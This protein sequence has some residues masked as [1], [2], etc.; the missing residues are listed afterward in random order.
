M[1]LNYSFGALV[2]S[3]PGLFFGGSK[4][5]CLA[6]NDDLKALKYSMLNLIITL[7]LIGSITYLI[8]FKVFTKSS[9]KLPHIWLE[10]K[11]L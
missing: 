6:Q 11:L 4:D 5:A 2:F 8:F 10:V 7:I 1:L 3:L 9:V